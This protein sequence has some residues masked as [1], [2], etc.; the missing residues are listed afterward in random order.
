MGKKVLCSC[1]MGSVV[2]DVSKVGAVKTRQQPVHAQQ[3]LAGQ[4]HGI[5]GNRIGNWTLGAATPGHHAQ[6]RDARADGRAR[7]KKLGG[8]RRR[9]GRYQRRVG[10]S[11]GMAR[12][13]KEREAGRDRPAP[14]PAGHVLR[15]ATGRSSKRGFVAS[16]STELD[17]VSAER[18][19]G[20]G[21]RLVSR[22]A[23]GR[24]GRRTEARRSGGETQ[25][26]E[27]LPDTR[28]AFDSGAR[29]SPVAA[30]TSALPMRP[31]C[32]R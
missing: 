24:I 17:E 28:R 29:S 23:V 5:V 6:T 15:S 14:A 11:S 1:V 2:A 12:V 30:P 16:V 10:V 32:F 27:E 21:S 3:T 7:H 8:N 9:R 4:S 13:R 19:V 25:V 20:P 22:Q 18:F 31:C 26:V